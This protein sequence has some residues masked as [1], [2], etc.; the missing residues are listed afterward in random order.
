MRKTVLFLLI[1]LAASSAH[2]RAI[3]VDYYHQVGCTACRAFE[4]VIEEV[5]SEGIYELNV[6]SYEI[7][8]DPDG[9]NRF[10]QMASRFGIPHERWATPTVVLDNSTYFIGALAKD[11]FESEL[12]R[13]LAGGCTPQGGN[14]SGPSLLVN[15]AAAFAAGLISGFNPC[16]LAVLLFL[17]SYSLGVSE[18]KMRLVRLT[19]AFSFGIFT[20]YFLVGWG[21]LAFSGNFDIGLVSRLIAGIV[22][23]LGLW[24]IKDHKNPRS[25]LVETPETVRGMGESFT[26]KNSAVTSFML[27]AVFS[28]VKA[29]CVGGVYLAIINMASAADVGT[30]IT[31]V[32]LL[33]SYNLGLVFPLL[34]VSAAVLLGVPP[35]AIEQWR[36]RNKYSM[37]IFLGLTLVLVGLLM[38]WQEGV[39]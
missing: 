29:P 12:D 25:I 31:A 10:E 28:L 15:P 6:S 37:R 20:V 33:L 16:L 11:G 17:I 5:V 27:G 19:L 4:G 39:I 8:F 38:L 18:N 2:A 30:K 14:G 23:V 26:Q 1:M 24:T 9:L 35:N 22:M 32:P 7:R 36:E 34:L 21:L 3:Q 13:C